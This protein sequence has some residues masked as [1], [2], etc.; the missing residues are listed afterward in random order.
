MRR[1]QG[2]DPAPPRNDIRST[3]RRLSASTRLSHSRI[4]FQ[5]A[6]VRLTSFLS[7]S[8]HRAPIVG[9][10]PANDTL[11][12]TLSVNDAPESSGSNRNGG[13]LHRHEEPGGI[14]IQDDRIDVTDT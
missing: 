6:N 14:A 8:E 12:D 13:S 3:R 7:K 2:S 4:R 10:I 5:L 9:R 11:A 1:R